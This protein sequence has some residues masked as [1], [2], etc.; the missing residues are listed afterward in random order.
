[1]VGCCYNLVT[2]RLGPWTYKLPVLRP[3]N[4]RLTQTSSAYDSHGFPMSERLASYH[5]QGG[6]GI[7]MNITA[8][9][10]A[11]QAPRNWTKADCDSFFTRH[12]YRALL[13][14]IFLDRGIVEHPQLADDVMGGASPRG[15]SGG[16]QPIILGSLRKSCYASFIAYVHGAIAKLVDGAEQGSWIKDCLADLT[17][18]EI[19]EYEKKYQ[20]KRHELSVIW[21]LMAFSAGVLESAIVVDRWL[22]LKEQDEVAD[23][24]VQSVF[25]HKQSPRNLVV[26]GIKR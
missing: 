20:G 24:W 7:R 21:S 8:R 26:T 15:W 19:M 4:A 11:V 6:L 17:D 12:F 25:D 5:H 22:W 1:M 18:D 3:P 13:Q 9:M 2:E 10:M 16:G 14:R 23:C